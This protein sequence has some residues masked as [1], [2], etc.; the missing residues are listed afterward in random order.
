M[1]IQAADPKFEVRAVLRSAHES[2]IAQKREILSAIF[3][4]VGANLDHGAVGEHGL[5]QSAALPLIGWSAFEMPFLDFAVFGCHIQIHLD[6]RIVIL[7]PGNGAS[8]GDGLFNVELRCKRMVG[9]ERYRRKQERA[10]DCE[11]KVGDC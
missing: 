1:L 4:A 8:E 5:A 7:D 9:A 6:M 10:G 2:E 11:G 3:G